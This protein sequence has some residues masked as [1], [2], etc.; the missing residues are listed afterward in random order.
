MIALFRSS[1]DGARES[2]LIG[3]DFGELPRG[4]SSFS[5]GVLLSRV[6]V[7]EASVATWQLISSRTQI[8][9]ITDHEDARIATWQSRRRSAAAYGYVD[10]RRAKKT[11]AAAPIAEM[12]ETKHG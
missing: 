12:Q 10:E 11:G 9:A 7:R 2:G 1:D 3:P 4:N 5:S 8:C 6:S